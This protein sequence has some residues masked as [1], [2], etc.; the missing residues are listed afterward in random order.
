MIIQY[1]NKVETATITA[2]SN[3][4]DF[5]FAVGLIDSRLSRISR[6]L[7]VDDEWVKFA[8]TGATSATYISI[9]NHN[10][11]S[12]ATVTIQGNAT[13]AWTSPSFEQVL[14]VADNM[15][16]SLGSQSYQYYR[17]RIQDAT[18][19]DGYIEIGGIYLGGHLS[20]PG[21]EPA[22]NITEKSNSESEKSISGQLYGDKRLQYKTVE[23]TF[24][25]ISQTDKDAISALFAEVDRTKPFVMF[26]W[27]D[28]PTIF[29]PLYCNL[30]SDLAWQ[31]PKYQLSYSLKLTF[32]ECF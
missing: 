6:T 23:T 24:T 27:E 25:S 12:S 32:E 15:C 5:T 31:K 11:T 18:N 4:P 8:F 26:L 29:P 9:F 13:D 14:T 19:T 7:D 17:L 10:F 3:N 2:S 16:V 21:F 1:I 28:D 22:V 20:M 30:T